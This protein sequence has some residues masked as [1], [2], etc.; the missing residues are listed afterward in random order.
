MITPVRMPKLGETDANS[1]IIERWIFTEGQTVRKGQGLLIVAT[2]K[3]SIEVEARAGGVVRKI[4]FNEGES[5]TT[6]T[7]I[8]LIGPAKSKI[9]AE[10]LER[11]LSSGQAYSAVLSKGGEIRSSDGPEA[12]LQM[13]TVSSMQHGNATLPP[14]PVPLPHERHARMSPRARR[15]AEELKVP[16]QALGLPVDG[17]R[18]TER[19][20][21]AAAEALEKVPATPTA[22]QLARDKGL[23]L[24][25]YAEMQRD[26]HKLRAEDIERV[27][28]RPLRLP[29]ERKPL[30]PMRRAIA[31]HMAYAQQFIPQFSVDT[32]VQAEPLLT[33]RKQLQLEWG[34]REAPSVDDFF[35]R[36][37][38]MLLADDDFKP[39]R[40]VLDGNDLVYRGEIGVGLAISLD[41][42]GVIVP[43]LK[44]VD[45]MPLREIAA[46]SR[47]VIAQARHKTLKPSQYSGGLVTISNL[48]MADVS[49][50]RAI[51]RPGESA[52]LA[53][54]SPQPRPVFM[55]E[56]DEHA[57]RATWQLSLSCDHRLV[58]GALA[59]T[60]LSK[61]KSLIDSPIRLI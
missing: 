5:V 6:G 18:I 14:S 27:A 37:V 41:E 52:I 32:I 46:A 53:I 57:I 26:G 15:I 51:V 34:K 40:A 54:P 38:G 59:A 13:P 29:A 10:L 7:T 60:F 30:K 33:M 45:R 2:D 28:P 17:K 49:S 58:D 50:F 24:T 21:R 12:R 23:D 42:H 25:R 8:A 3:T 1:F 56:N 31:E 47:D 22:R 43:V 48:G 9:P 55:G 35:I 20:V 19:E 39:F 16:F 11:K 61:L 44:H 4:L 36:A